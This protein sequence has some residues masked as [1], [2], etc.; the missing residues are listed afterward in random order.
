MRNNYGGIE[1]S[2]L[3]LMLHF[4][5]LLSKVGLEEEKGEGDWRREKEEE[6]GEGMAK[7]FCWAQAPPPQTPFLSCFQ[8]YLASEDKG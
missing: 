4:W 6:E 5:P 3:V 8:I 1:Y 7:G 2:N